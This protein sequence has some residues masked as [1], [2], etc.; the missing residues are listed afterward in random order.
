MNKLGTGLVFAAAAVA[1]V[2]CQST[3]EERPNILVILLDDAGYNDFGF[4]GCPDLKTPNIDAL[5]ADGVCFTDGHVSASVSGPSRAGILTGRYQQRVGY[6]CNP[7]G[8]DG[9]DVGAV[10][11]G[12]IFQGAGYNTA[13]FGKWHQ[14]HG[15]ADQHPNNRG[16]DYFYGFN[17]GSRSYFYR[18]NTNDKAGSSGNLQ[19]NGEQITFE[20]YMTDVLAKATCDYLD[21]I[22]AKNDDPFMIYLA[23]NAVHTP[24]EATEEDLALFEGHPRQTLAAMTWAVD[25]GI[26]DVVNK[27]KEKGIYDNTLIFFL[28]DNGGAHNNTSR[29]TPLKGFKG[30]KFEGGHRVPFF[31]TYGKRF[32]GESY[33]GLISSLDIIATSAAAAGI[34]T[35][36]LEQPLDGVDIMP[37]VTGKS[38]GEPHDILFWRKEDMAAVRQGDYK[39]IRVVGVGERLYNLEENLG[40]D[41]DLSA[42]MPELKSQME[43][44]LEAW[45][46]E[47]VNP[48]LWKEGIWND[49]T[50]IIHRDL[51]E[52]KP[53]SCYSP[54]QMKRL[55]K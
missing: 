20:G 43:A 30:N 10:T 19:I 29:N 25:R 28:S 6:E 50:R 16:F 17:T 5:A 36:T 48:L 31:M 44:S 1:G 27:L 34:E 54:D 22:T 41:N 45:E 46:S 13:A 38:E 42:A 24:M 4:M 47:L 11:I 14:G 12:D 2:S 40:E 51:M 52:N 39:L 8:G 7:E 21:D 9:L 3:T 33:D 32:S 15:T 53:V 55:E 49:V 26:G 18:P 23:F 37:Y 35:S